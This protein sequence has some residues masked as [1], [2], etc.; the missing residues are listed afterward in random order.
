MFNERISI[1]MCTYNGE[2]YLAQQLES[3][4]NQSLKP[5]ELVICDDGSSDSTIAIINDFRNRLDLDINLF[6]NR[7]NLGSTQNFQKAIGLCKYEIIALSDQDDVWEPHKLTTIINK[8]RGSQDIGMVFSNASL[9][10]DNL[11]SINGDLWTR[12]GFNKKKQNK[13]LAGNAFNVFLNGDTVTG[14]TMAFRSSYIKNILPIGE[15]WVHDGWIA[16]LLSLNSS[17]KF[18]PLSLIQY[19][20]HTEQQ[21]GVPK[22]NRKKKSFINREARKR[23]MKAFKLHQ[24]S[25]YKA[26]SVRFMELYNH[27]INSLEFSKNKK[28]SKE[29]KQKLIHLDNIINMPDKRSK[30]VK[31]ILKELIT[32]RYHK[33]SGGFSRALSDFLY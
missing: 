14:A 2:K 16:I 25:S 17:I 10:D 11:L 19:R 6:I 26:D 23:K 5:D 22:E 24:L 8:F 18:T 21:I 30:K 32:L 20:Q 15:N 4:A 31:P 1:A 27:I 9:V 13:I 28:A 33:Y 3:I 29:I 12:V 7:S